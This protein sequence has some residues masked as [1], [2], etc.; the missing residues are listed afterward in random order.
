MIAVVTGSNGFIGSHLVEALLQ[1]DYHI[2]CLDIQEARGRSA[3][4]T[5]IEHYTVDCGDLDALR[6]TQV[7][8]NADYV[9]HLA[10]VSKRVK[11]EE[12]RCGNVVTTGNVL[13]VLVEKNV[14]I[15]RFVYISTQ[16]AAGPAS[17]LDHPVTELSEPKPI[18][19]YGIS[20]L[21]AEHV[22]RELA[23]Q[24]PYT[25]LRPGTVYGPRDVD[26]L[27]VFKQINRHMSVYPAYRTKYINIIFVTV[28]VNGM[29]QAARTPEAAGKTYFLCN[30]DPVMWQD[31]HRGI[32]GVQNKRVFELDIPQC[33]VDVIA[34]ILGL[35]SKITGYS[36]MVNS[37]KIAL[38]RPKFWVCS[39]ERAKR[40][41]G[42]AAR[43]P[44][45]QGLETTYRWYVENGWL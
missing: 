15:K 43:V 2:R 7:F 22:V 45:L 23:A 29:L 3:Q 24:L 38:S 36:G 1:Q 41:F 40:D 33:V 42:F 20:K 44:L 10:G 37:E 32:A 39:P 30:D 11:L 5:R 9:F 27:A 25:I 31:I 8:T 14:R 16:A 26:F 21:E 35:H 17:S 4:D 6:Q 13:Q 18:E 19:N 34:K 12:F 28:L